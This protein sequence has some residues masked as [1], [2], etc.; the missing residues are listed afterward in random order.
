VSGEPKVVEDEP[1]VDEA[2]TLIA[3]EPAVPAGPVRIASIADLEANQLL[4]P[5]ARSG[6]AAGLELEPDTV[7]LRC[8]YK[9]K[10]AVS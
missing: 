3:V 8:R 9:S 4:P 10:E 1:I 5:S 7:Y 2:E 6:C